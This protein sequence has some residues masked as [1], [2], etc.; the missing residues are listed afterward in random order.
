[1]ERPILI[2]AAICC[3]ICIISSH[4]VLEEFY[5]KDSNV[6]YG[7]SLKG[8]NAAGFFDNYGKTKNI[9]E[10]TLKCCDAKKCNV[11]VMDGRTKICMGVR[12]FNETSCSTVPATKGEEELQ[13]AHLTGRSLDKNVTIDKKTAKLKSNFTEDRCPTNEIMY[14]MKLSGGLHA[15]RFTDIGRVRSIKTCV[16]YCCGD[17]TECDLAFMLGKR[18]YLVKC[19]NEEKCSPLPAS[20]Y[21]FEQKMAFVSP[22]LFDKRKKIMKVPSGLQQH[23]LQ[24]TQSKVY[25]K[26]K[27]FGGNDAGKFTHVGKVGKMHICSKMC[28]ENHDCDL[29]Y[30]FGKDCFLVK[31]YS[32]KGCRVVPD[33]DLRKSTDSSLDKQIQY[34]IKRKFGVKVGED[35][36]IQDGK[37]TCGIDGNVR[38]KTILVKGMLAGSLKRQRNVKEMNHC[39]EKCCSE[40]RCHVAMTMGPICYSMECANKD[41]C[42]P[43]AAPKSMMN[44]N[45]TIAYVKRGSI[46]MAP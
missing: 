11:A 21:S 17:A 1:M 28:C 37:E 15:G 31:C 38:N 42:K 12:C 33:E 2:Y 18:C 20:D 30:M 8:G 46:S 45:P 22:W 4:T 40:K 32:E 13:I 34:V 39:L 26:S 3:W 24:C 25:E 29:A 10:C 27:L 6:E 9:Q 36:K 19:Y 43:K 44:Q 5:C 7:R 35:G 41:G 14:N 23:H 16:R